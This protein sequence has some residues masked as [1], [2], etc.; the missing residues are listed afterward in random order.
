MA[1]RTD[2]P[3]AVVSVLRTASTKIMSTIPTIY[4]FVIVAE[5]TAKPDLVEQGPIHMFSDCIVCCGPA[6]RCY[7]WQERRNF[8]MIKF[9]N[10]SHCEFPRLFATTNVKPAHFGLRM[11]R[12]DEHPMTSNALSPLP[13]NARMDHIGKEAIATRHCDFGNPSEKVHRPLPNS[14]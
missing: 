11:R 6:R 9:P 14:E 4:K 3:D 8:V 12:R 13:K 2:N 7:Y 10:E 5:W 1:V